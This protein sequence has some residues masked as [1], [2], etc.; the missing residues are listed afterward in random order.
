MK[1]ILVPVEQHEQADVGPRLAAM[2]AL[3]YESLVEAFALRP[4]PRPALDWDPASAAMLEDS[5]RDDDRNRA[6]A[7]AVLA[8]IM[9]D[10]GLKETVADGEAPGWVWNEQPLAGDNFLGSR[11]RAFD[12]TVVGQ[13]RQNG[14]SITTLEAALF[15]SGGPIL[16]APTAP[17]GDF[18]RDVVV[19]WN[20][21]S[22]TARTIAFA[23]P[24]LRRAERVTILADDGE[25]GHAPSGQMVRRRLARQGIAA[26]LQLLEGG[27]IRS[28]ETILDRA[29]GLNCDLL[30]KGAYTQSRIRQMI[31]GG[32]TKHTL[33]HA[34][35]PVFMAH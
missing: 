34:T 10:V 15:D 28:G 5:R 30:V 14:S 25:L 17:I 13:P 27:R 1:T 29:A 8:G 9:A 19:V 32:A 11:G 2:T 18:G 12:L 31:F 16:I 35:V 20:G 6:E 23:L 21:S 4:P 3:R 26:D 24:I 33:A 22:E 7:Y